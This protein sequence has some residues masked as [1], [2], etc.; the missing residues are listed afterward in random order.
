MDD[1]DWISAGTF[2]VPDFALTSGRR[3]WQTAGHKYISITLPDDAE[4]WDKAKVCVRLIPISKAAGTGNSYD[5]GSIDSVED[6]S[7]KCDNSL[8]YLSVRYNK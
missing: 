6:Q 3:N 5:G 4:I 8:N 1:S 7:S 2:T